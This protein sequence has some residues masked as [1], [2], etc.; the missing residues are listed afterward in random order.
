MA[1]TSTAHFSKSAY[2]YS[3]PDTSIVAYLCH[4]DTSFVV[5]L[6]LPSSLLPLT[7][8][9][10]SVSV[11]THTKLIDATP[12]VPPTSPSAAAPSAAFQRDLPAVTAMQ[13]YC[14]VGSSSRG[15]G[16]SNEVITKLVEVAFTD[17]RFKE[18]SLVWC[19][20]LPETGPHS[21]VLRRCGFAM[22]GQAFDTDASSSSS[23]ST[24][25]TT[26]TTKD[27]EVKRME[28][29][30][31]IGGAFTTRGTYWY[32]QMSYTMWLKRSQLA[33]NPSG[34]HQYLI[35]SPKVASK[36][37]PITVP[38]TLCLEKPT[39]ATYESR[40]IMRGT[41]QAD[42]D[43]ALQI[44]QNDAKTMVH[45]RCMIAPE[46]GFTPEVV[47]CLFKFR[48]PIPS[49]TFVFMKFIYLHVVHL[50]QTNKRLKTSYNFVFGIVA[51]R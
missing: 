36:L 31:P 33:T 39:W 44:I 22:V 46:G 24:A 37:A 34:P 12:A 51:L 14:E 13:L 26:T 1:A 18:V 50:G 29:E 32:W 11:V 23:P 28:A 40:V 8:P 3:T 38:Q 4:V 47:S 15:R 9:S 5:P 27:G 45:L 16:V 49:D 35:D 19:R 6:P 48:Y 30:P 7:R 2:T 41:P 17:E 25:T 20:T 42:T 43:D 10:S 21:R